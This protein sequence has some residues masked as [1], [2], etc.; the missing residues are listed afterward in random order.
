MVVAHEILVT[1]LS[2]KSP[3]PLRIWGWDIGLGLGFGL[4]NILFVKI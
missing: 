4:V 1:T 3:F 2:P